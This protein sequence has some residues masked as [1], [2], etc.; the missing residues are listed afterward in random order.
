MKYSRKYSTNIQTF[1]K[2]RTIPKYNST[3]FSLSYSEC[4]D[5]LCNIVI[6]FVFCYVTDLYITFIKIIES[7]ESHWITQIYR[8]SLLTYVLH[9]QWKVLYNII[10][11]LVLL[12][13]NLKN[14]DTYNREVVNRIIAEALTKYFPEDET[15]KRNSPR[16]KKAKAGKR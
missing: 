9:C 1:E 12:S 10:E 14:G 8:N 11:S 3:L 7:Q 2:K 13:F 5:F 16:T 15:L 6:A 4:G